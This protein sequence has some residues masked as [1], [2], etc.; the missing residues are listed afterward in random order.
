VWVWL[1]SRA[2]PTSL[3]KDVLPRWLGTRASRRR[4]LAY[5]AWLA[6]ECIEVWRR[7]GAAAIQPF[8]Y[9]SA[10]G[11]RTANWFLGPL[12]QLRPKPVL[13]AVKEACAP[14]GTSIAL[15]DRHFLP[16]E[17]RTIDV[18]LFNDSPDNARLVAVVDLLDA[19]NHVVSN[20]QSV[21]ADLRPGESAI[22][23]VDVTFPSEIGTYSLVST[24]RGSDAASRKVVHI[25]P[26]PTATPA[27]RRRRIATLDPRGEITSFL[28]SLGLDLLPP[29]LVNE[30]DV[31]ILGEG[32]LSSSRFVALRSTIARFVR[33]G[34]LLV[35]QEPEFGID[36]AITVGIAGNVSLSIA[37]RRDRDA[38]GY[39]SVAHVTSACPG[40]VL[41]GLRPEHIGYFNGGVG[42]IVVAEADVSFSGRF[43]TWMQCG[44]GLR[45][46]ALLAKQ[47]GRGLV[48]ANR[49]QTRGRLMGD[50]DGSWPRRS[51]P[52]AQRLLINLLVLRSSLAIKGHR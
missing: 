30:S 31:M 19:H 24:V 12:A 25:L 48:V 23:Q 17:C 6:R 33:H 43:A 4:C 1:D 13:T 7:L 2:R 9:L 51:D 32:A 41:R 16:S 45:G 15:W 38:G 36:D 40:T 42:G 5:Q 47:I 26:R 18:H 44:L 22:R 10:D 27:L 50:S 46:N 11:G 3:L 29:E 37:P 20:S 52:V 34:G 35:L 39:D 8:V 49:L 21:S 28:G 14:L